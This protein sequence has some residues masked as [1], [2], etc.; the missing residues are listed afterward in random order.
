MGKILFGLIPSAIPGFMRCFFSFVTVLFLFTIVNHSPS[1]AYSPQS[2][3]AAPTV[4]TDPASQV[5]HNSATLRGTVNA[6]GLSTTALFQYRIVDGPSKTTVS[7]QTVIGTS[8]TEVSFNIIA[9]LPGTTYYYRLVAENDAGTVYGDEVSFTT[10]DM[11]TSLTADIA[12]PT[13]SI[14]INN[15]AYRTNSLIVTLELS[16]ADNIGVTGYYFSTSAIP[17]SP[18]TAGWTSATPA[19]NYKED[20]SYTLSGDDGKNTVYVWYKDASGNISDVASDSIIVDTTP[21]TI[22]IANPTSGSTYKTASKTINISGSASDSTSEIN[23]VVWS[24]SKG[25]DETESK[26]ISWN[27]SNV[28]LLEGDN[29]ITIKATD[30]LGNTGTATITI[31]YAAGNNPPTVITGHATGITTD[32]ATLTGTVNAEELSTTAWF[33]YGTSSESY[34]HTSSMI[35]I[36]SSLL[37]TPIDNYISGLLAGTTYYYRLAARNS[38]GAAYGAEMIFNT[39]PPK[40]KI[41]GYV[42]ESIS[43]KPIESARI[44]LKGINARKKAFKILFSDADGFYEFNELDADTYDIFAIKTGLKSARHEVKL[45][46]GE[47]NNVEIKLE[48]IRGEEQKR[49][50]IEDK[51]G[52]DTPHPTPNKPEETKPEAQNPKQI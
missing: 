18:H 1:A 22:T 52:T 21:P 33:Q 6:N 40:G 38:A 12:S 3:S 30:S 50:L 20:V 47:K 31:T 27:I 34:S 14:S 26:T 43:G 17:P 45:L 48:S 4:T 25:K 23:N 44:R 16:A 13:G 29:V 46:E 2:S 5:T 15:G 51:K 9:L 37:D 7:T 36:E 32:F 49:D 19:I 35:T 11:K 10:T 8:D 41:S 28:D 24:T 42:M 39:K